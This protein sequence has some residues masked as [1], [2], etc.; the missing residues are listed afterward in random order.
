MIA[1]PDDLALA[2]LLQLAS[3]ALPVGAYSYSQ[4]LE[5]AIEA[6][7]V[8]DER[9]ALEWIE[10]V[11]D[12]TLATMDA[13]LFL[14]LSAAWASGGE[15]AAR[16]WNDIVLASRESAELRAESVQMGYSL[17]RLL[18]ELGEAHPFNAW[19]EVSFPAAYTY[20]AARC[21]VSPRD[22]LV[23]YLWGWAENQAMAAVKAVPLGQSAGQRLLFQ[24]APRLVDC[25]ARAEAIGDEAL[26]N[27]APGYALLCATH[28]TQYSRLFRS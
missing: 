13:P 17:V 22:A 4:G 2:R 20:W 1:Q 3:P 25:A 11:L 19:E 7:L 16:E 8:H 9:S 18:D 12:L 10:S 27:A 21:G 28:E 24:L 14:R 23:G 26:A 6:G 15:A 5:A